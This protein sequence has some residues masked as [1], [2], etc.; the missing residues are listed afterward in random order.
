MGY[1]VKAACPCGYS[2]D[3]LAVGVGMSIG[4]LR[5]DLASCDA[6]RRISSVRT[7]DSLRCKYCGKDAQPVVLEVVESKTGNGSYEVDSTAHYRCPRC[8]E[9][10]LI[11]PLVETW[12]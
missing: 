9:K 3:Q 4:V 10:N 7:G 2:E 11:L 5:L 1:I 6:C 12:N 8:H